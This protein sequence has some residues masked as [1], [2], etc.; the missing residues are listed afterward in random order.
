[1]HTRLLVTGPVA[2]LM[3]LC[4][5]GGRNAHRAV[6]PDGPHDPDLVV[7]AGGYHGNH[8]RGPF[9]A[10]RYSALGDGTTLY[11]VTYQDGVTVLSKDEISHH[12]LNIQRDGTYVFDGSATKIG[13]LKPGSVLVLSG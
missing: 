8:F 10:P 6:L 13:S 12:L 9:Y 7:P 3:L 4:S 2:V 11:S 5:C 1:M